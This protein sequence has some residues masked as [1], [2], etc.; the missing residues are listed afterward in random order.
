MEQNFSF[1]YLN[2]T[3]Q[4]FEKHLTKESISNKDRMFFFLEVILNSIKYQGII[5]G[6]KITYHYI[7]CRFFSRYI[8]EDVYSFLQFKIAFLNI[9][10]VRNIFFELFGLNQYYF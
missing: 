3:V 9:Q 4:N 1:S 5:I 7:K 8:K 10:S 6:L 2:M